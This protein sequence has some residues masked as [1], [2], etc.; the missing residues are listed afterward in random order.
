[1]TK[2]HGVARGPDHHTDHGE[3]DVS[4]A[5]WRVGTI[6]Y[7]QHVAH[8]HEQGVGVLYVPSRVLRGTRERTEQHCHDKIYR[9]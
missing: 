3:P 5:L 9:L 4:H 7:T 1:M 6:S 2:E 8:G